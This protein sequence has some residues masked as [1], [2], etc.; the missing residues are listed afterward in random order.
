MAI[1]NLSNEQWDALARHTG[2]KLRES[3]FKQLALVNSVN[4][5]KDWLTEKDEVELN[6]QTIQEEINWAKHVACNALERFDGVT[7]PA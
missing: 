4:R 7:I 3:A 6:Y 5:L 1:F 2:Y